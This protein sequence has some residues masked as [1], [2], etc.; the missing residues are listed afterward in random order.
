MKKINAICLVLFFCVSGIAFSIDIDYGMALSGE[1]RSGAINPEGGSE[2]GN[3]GKLLLAP[4]LSFPAGNGS[5]YLSAGISAN[6]TEKTIFVPELLQ[7]EFSH[8]FDSL[9]LRAGRIPWQDTSTFT[10]KGR[11]DG[12]E[13]VLDTGKI[14]IGAAA[15]Y[16]GLLY[17]DTADINYSF[18]DTANY[19]ADFDWNNFGKT[20]FAPRRLL[21]SV[22]GEF[23]GLPFRRGNLYAGILAQFDLSDA[24]EPYHTQYLLFR[25][26]IDYRIFDLDA[27]GAIALENTDEGGIKA[28]FA[29]TLDGGVRIPANIKNRLSMNL[30]WASGIGPDLAAFFPLVREAQ[31]YVL[32]PCF[33]GIM[34]AGINFEAR[35]LPSL[36]AEIGGRY[37]L[38]TDAWSFTD[39][40]ITEKEYALGLEACGNLLWVP[41]SDLSFSLGGGI[42]LPQTGNAMRDSSHP[43]GAAPVRWSVTLAAIFSL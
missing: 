4:W 37:F 32:K 5:F 35:L 21:A 43:N 38:R 14:L 40:D 7:M 19:H 34:A 12:I 20:Y 23:P 36:S 28:A 1:F 41:F 33:A 18:T 11:F 39:P 30:K 2:T 27:S 25:H 26:T 24:D 29:F 6:F 10:A 15:F 22:Y 42:F 16:T 17:K 13:L 31:G 9:F 3:E 8:R